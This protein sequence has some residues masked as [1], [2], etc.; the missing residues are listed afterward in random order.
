MQFGAHGTLGDF[1]PR[2]AAPDHVHSE[3]YYGVVV[4]GVVKNPFGEQP[5]GDVATAK[6]L[7]AGSFWAVPANAVHTTAC[8]GDPDSNCIFYF[9]S[10]GA[11]DFDT[12][13]S[14]GD[15]QAGGTLEMSATEISAEL[16]KPEAEVSPFARMF[17]VW[18]DRGVGAHGTMG[19]FIPFGASPE[20]THSISYHGMVLSG[21]MVNPFADESIEDARQL[22]PGDYWFVPAGVRH[23]TACVSAEPCRFYFHAEG[24]FDFAPTANDSP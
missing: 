12:D 11:F 23:V 15:T 14:A 13:I 22:H 7:P 21:V 1:A 10:V 19:E 24:A 8:D 20:H 9:H 4:S 18:G 16:A 5:G 2:S 17:T 6:P 3:T